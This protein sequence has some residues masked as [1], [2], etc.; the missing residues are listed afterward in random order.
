MMTEAS[1]G[2]NNRILHSRISSSPQRHRP[3]ESFDRDRIQG[4][5]SKTNTIPHSLNPSINNLSSMEPKSNLQVMQSPTSNVHRSENMINNIPSSEGKRISTAFSFSSSKNLLTGP[6]IQSNGFGSPIASPTYN[7]N[8]STGSLYYSSKNNLS[9]PLHGGPASAGLKNFS[10]ISSNYN[11]QR[12]GN[13]KRLATET[14]EGLNP[15]S[16]EMSLTRGRSS[17]SD[18]SDLKRFNPDRFER[19]SNFGVTFLLNRCSS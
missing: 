8:M 3:D 12:R 5:H 2:P 14:E 7:L 9:S 4:Y 16:R 10:A 6:N 11:T 18:S 1:P 17:Y 13:E 15:R 19:Q